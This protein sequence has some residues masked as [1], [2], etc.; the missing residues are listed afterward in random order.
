MAVERLVEE[1]KKL[2]PQQKEELFRKLGVKSSKTEREERRGGH[3]DPLA[4]LIGMLQGPG[5]GSR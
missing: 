5:T 3:D 1:I 2:S 4:E